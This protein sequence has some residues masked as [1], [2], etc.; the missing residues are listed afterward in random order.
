MNNI[1][2]TSEREKTINIKCMFNSGTDFSVT[3]ISE[4]MDICFCDSVICTTSYLFVNEYSTIYFCV[5]RI[6]MS[7]RRCVYVQ[8]S[9]FHIFMPITFTQN[10]HIGSKRFFL[11][12]SA[13]FSQ[14]MNS[15]FIFARQKHF[16]HFFS[17]INKVNFGDYILAERMKRCI[18]KLQWKKKQ[19]GNEIYKKIN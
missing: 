17:V 13:L 4:K 16:N 19:M 1:R 2:C 5:V 14:I 11:F 12:V 6:T 8:I 10:E 7:H 3:T 15:I 18:W 9:L